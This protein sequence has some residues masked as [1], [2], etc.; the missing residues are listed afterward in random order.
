MEGLS[1][2]F[3]L[4]NASLTGFAERAVGGWR[5]GGEAEEEEEEEDGVSAIAD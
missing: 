3:S 1:D 4:S 2:T 5:V